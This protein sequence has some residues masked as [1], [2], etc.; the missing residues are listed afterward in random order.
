LYMTSHDARANMNDDSGVRCLHWW[1]HPN[2]D[3]V[4]MQLKR[5]RYNIMELTIWYKPEDK[6]KGR[7]RGEV[8]CWL[9]I[10]M[11]QAKL[12]DK[13]FNILNHDGGHLLHIEH[14]IPAVVQPADPAGA[15][16]FKWTKT[17]CSGSSHNS[18]SL[19]EVAVHAMNPA[20]LFSPGLLI[21]K[22]CTRFEEEIVDWNCYRAKDFSGTPYYNR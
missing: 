18:A 5:L 20:N 10:P 4:H 8:K 3:L 15:K 17:Q 16:P 22:C 13:P 11:D 7:F 19:W 14:S 1:S 6:P 12:M 21:Y 2:G 9:E